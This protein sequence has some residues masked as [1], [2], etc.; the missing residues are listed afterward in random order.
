LSKPSDSVLY[1]P[2]IE[3]QS[4]NW[5]KLSLLF[6]DKI[7]RIVPPSY[8]PCDSETV[9]EATRHG[10]I[11]NISVDD[12]DKKIAEKKFNEFYEDLSF[13]PAGLEM[14]PYHR[15]HT[16]KID[17]RLYP[18]LEKIAQKWYNENWLYPPAHVAKGY[19]FC[20]SK[21]V[22]DRRNVS[23]ATDD[24]DAWTI[25]PYFAENGDFGED[26]YNPDAKSYYSAL[27]IKDI[28]PANISE[29]SIEEIIKFLD[30]KRDLKAELR[31]EIFGFVSDLSECESVD[32]INE[33]IADYKGEIESAKQELMKS[34]GFWNKDGLSF[35]LS[36]GIPLS[37]SVYKALANPSDPFSINDVGIGVITAI[38]A[39]LSNKYRR[40]S[41]RGNSYY[42]YLID[43]DQRLVGTNKYPDYSYAFNEFIND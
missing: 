39:Y 27:L 5:V 32:F 16:D 36:I 9:I 42:S 19:M 34:A 20:L 22:A 38:A 10:L 25:S 29:V 26:L 11:K 30:E 31:N 14:R 41:D 4:D 35:L 3:F 1:Y 6:W 43:M 40:S 12:K 23:R 18:K 21:I 17:N 37:N 15:V 13:I 24:N 7:Y 28:F 2:S 33:T 8:T